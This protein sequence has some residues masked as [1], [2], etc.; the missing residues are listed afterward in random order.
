MIVD[1]ADFYNRAA[2][3]AIA[4]ADAALGPCTPSRA[5]LDRAARTLQLVEGA[6]CAARRPIPALVVPSRN[7]AATAVSRRTLADLDAASLPRTASA[8]GDRRAYA[9][10]TLSGRIPS[11]GEVTG[12]EVAALV[13]ELRKL[14]WIPAKSQDGRALI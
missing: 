1:T 10:M 3:L 13:A 12:E 8:I 4:A 7:K 6:A 5:D 11:P 9:E 2:L 14:G